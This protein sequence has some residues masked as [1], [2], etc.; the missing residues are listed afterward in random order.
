MLGTNSHQNASEP[1]LLSRGGRAALL[2][3]IALTA[4]ALQACNTTE[5]VGKDIKAAGEG[6]EEA[7]DDAKD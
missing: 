3:G 2:A 6:I 1:S 7:A 5:G 4:L